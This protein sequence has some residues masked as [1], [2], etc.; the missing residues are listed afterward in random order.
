MVQDR[1]SKPADRHAWLD[2]P[3]FKALLEEFDTRLDQFLAELNEEIED[4]DILDCVLQ[5][6][7][8]KRNNIKIEKI[9]S[10]LN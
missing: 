5:H 1:P 9:E 2:N 7:I 10:R 3:R 8:T 6:L 4:G